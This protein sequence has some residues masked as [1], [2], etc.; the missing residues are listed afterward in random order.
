MPAAAADFYAHAMST[1]LESRTG[2]EAAGFLAG[3][4]GL[5]MVVGV[6]L[7]LFLAGWFT[8]LDARPLPTPQPIPLP[9][10]SVQPGA[11]R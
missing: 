3:T 2:T 9:T 8:P 11:G 10:A 1:H 7:G 6:V 5:L 4:A